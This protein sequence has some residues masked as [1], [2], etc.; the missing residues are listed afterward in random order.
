ML[1]KL[2]FFKVVFIFNNIELTKPRYTHWKFMTKTK[3]ERSQGDHSRGSARLAPDQVSN[4][5]CEGGTRTNRA[6]TKRIRPIDA[7][8][9]QD[10]AY[11]ILETRRCL[12]YFS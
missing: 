10:T 3:L 1:A 6:V 8:Q 2:E 7:G 12:A 11:L 9:H 4:V 5:G